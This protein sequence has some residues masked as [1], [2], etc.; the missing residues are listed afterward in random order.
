MSRI[1]SVGIYGSS[2]GRN[3]GD[4]ALIAG[5]MDGID[6]ALKRRLVY[7]IPTYRPDYIWYQYDN[8][9][10]P[11]SML[12]WHGSV[13]MFG[14]PTALSFRRCDL[15]VIYDNM[16]FDR[17]LWNPLFNYMPAVWAYWTKAKRA[18]QVL[19]MYNVGCGP[20]TTDAGRKQL[21]Q[22]ADVCDFITVRDQDSLKLLRDVGVTHERIAVTADAALTMTPV[23]RERVSQILRQSGLEPGQECYAVNVNSYISSWSGSSKSDLSD[24]EFVNTF[25]AAV[26]K[27]A[28]EV[29]VPIVFIGTQHS[30][31]TITERVR[32]KVKNAPTHLISNVNYNHAEMKG[33]LGAMACLF[34]MRLHANILATSM[35][36]PTVALSFQK[37]VTSYYS[38]LGLPEN[39]ISFDSFSETT[40]VN[41]MLR[42]WRDRDQ[43]RKHLQ[44]RIP[45]LQEKSLLAADVVRRIDAG[46]SGAEA[47]QDI[48]RI[49]APQ[50]TQTAAQNA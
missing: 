34:A 31:I 48:Q 39:V 19:G 46:A 32:S 20:V 49:L 26:T 13:G 35:T 7:E 9:T 37:K 3:A 22:I 38:E 14:I 27:V 25:A 12:P 23:G 2:S 5:I 24:D 28:A 8:K 45:V 1:N 40:L 41:H 21:R 10:R 30:D 17:K 36:T 43:I 50:A 18:G 44:Q 6:L 11:A 42:G 47:I 4:A 15:N 16:L 33:V 29:N